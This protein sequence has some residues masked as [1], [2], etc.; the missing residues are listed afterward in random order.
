MSYLEEAVQHRSAARQLR[1]LA[2]ELDLTRSNNAARIARSHASKEEQLA[3]QAE[4]RVRISDGLLEL[5][6]AELEASMSG[7]RVV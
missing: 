6:I 7:S 5:E 3:E 2:E 4:Y 1:E